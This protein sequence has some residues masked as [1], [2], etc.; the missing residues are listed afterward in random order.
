MWKQA[1]G[2][3]R[4]G[5][6]TT[7][8]K[9]I[10]TSQLTLTA[11]EHPAI[12]DNTNRFTSG[13]GYTF[14]ANGNVVVDGYGRQFTFNGDNKQTKVRDAQ[15]NV[16][17]EY[18]FDGEGKRVK[19]VVGSDTTIFVYSG[20]KLIA[21][22]STETPPQ[23]PTTR[24]TVTDQLG[25]PRVIVDALG[26][27]VSRRDFLPFGEEVAPDGAY[28]T[29]AQKYGQTDYVR[30]KFTGY[31]K[32][33]ETGLDFAEA[34]MYQN[35]QGRFTAVDP[36]LAS[37]KSADP[38]TFNRYVYVLN[39]PLIHVDPTGLQTG[40]AKGKV[41]INEA[42]GQV[43]IFEG[44]VRKG[45]VPLER[46]IETTTKVNGVLHH[47]SITPG[48]WT[49]GGRVDGKKF[50]AAPAVAQ[51]VGDERVKMLAG[52]IAT[53]AEQGVIGMLKGAG[54]FAIN[55]ANSLTN[56]LGPIGAAA[57]VPNPAAIPN[58]SYDND[59]QASYGRATETG[60]VLG[61]VVAGG[62]LS[63]G[64]SASS[65]VPEAQPLSKGAQMVTEWLGPNAQPVRGGSD[66]MIRSAD[67][68]RQIRFDLINSHGLKPHINV[69]TFRP[70]YQG[71]P[72]MFRTGNE[73]IYP[74]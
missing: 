20:S 27:V 66:L 24:Y 32:D 13:Q 71:S 52:A 65:V 7:H 41:Y 18:L 53:T 26:Q 4:Y 58:I 9:W 17:G 3:D 69:E 19:K 56:P 15:N 74:K 12:N 46:N 42:K 51:P 60:L 1:F 44:R 64:A 59:A 30:Q 10:G 11:L 5:N 14:D 62:V 21:E 29:T 16:I 67:G 25:S 28:R 23:N 45:F 54:N 55:T 40:I 37:G 57:G 2:Y 47:M 36:L 8:Q 72:R 34:R 39:N 70:T 48:G 63:G 50:E 22:Y 38:Q 49:T 43:G 31:Q 68:T 35:L 73:H 33:Q 6:R 61:T